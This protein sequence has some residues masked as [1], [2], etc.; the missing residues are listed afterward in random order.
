YNSSITETTGVIL[1][2][3]NYRFTPEA[4]RPPYNNPNAPRN[5]TLYP[6]QLLSLLSTK[7]LNLHTKLQLGLFGFFKL[8]I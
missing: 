8:L 2:Y 7:A 6:L 1:F 4:Y 5:R 3:T